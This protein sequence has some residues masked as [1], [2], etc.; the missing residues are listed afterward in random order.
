MLGDI[1]DARLEAG[2]I[3]EE[4]VETTRIDYSSQSNDNA[5][6]D[7]VAG[8][9]SSLGWVGYAFADLNRDT[10]KL[11]GVD[12]GDGCVEPSPETIADGTY[13]VARLLYIY[14]N[15]ANVASNPALAAF[16]DFYLSDA[17][18]E[19]VAE[20]DY[21]QLPED[22]WAETVSAWEAVRPS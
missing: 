18:F 3:T 5:I 21:V 8:T 6:I 7:G 4:Q 17:G 20:A 22:Q 10:V 16:V 14:V 19:A 1:A 2:A 12:G 9:D 15:T 13:P 11:L